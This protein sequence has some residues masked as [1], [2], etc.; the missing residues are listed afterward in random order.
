M[1]APWL[2]GRPLADGAFAALRREVIFRGCKWD[3]QVGDVCTV[4]RAPLVLVRA[5]W[6]A[7]VALAERLDVELLEMERELLQRPDLIGQLALPRRLARALPGAMPEHALR[8]HRYDFHFTTEGIRLSEVNADVPG[9]LHEGVIAS[10]YA[11][12]SQGGRV[13][14]NVAAEL[15]AAVAARVPA[16]ATVA[17]VHATAYSDDR[18]V[19]NVLER[20][21]FERGLHGIAC[22]PDHLCWAPD[23]CEIVLGARREPV[24][25]VLR[26][27]PAEWLPACPSDA[28]WAGLVRGPVLLA[29]PVTS[30]LVQSKRL[31]L[32]WPKLRAS[33]AVWRS[34]LPPTYPSR[35]FF[36][37]G[38]RCVLKP[39]LGRVGEDIV[40]RGV[41][42]L[43][44]LA[45]VAAHALLHPRDYVAQRRFHPVAW[46]VENEH[47]Y[48]CVGVFTLDGRVVG[49]Y[50][51]ASRDLFVNETAIDTPVL[52]I[53]S[54]ASR[55]S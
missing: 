13:P 44:R 30:V 10:L 34:V 54:P 33:S 21:L 3:A 28:P 8:L 25:A 29:N 12:H 20:A 22:A 35:R 1:N 15:A 49:A 26:F 38:G 23:G 32:L 4:A 43:S 46:Q 50:G 39:N 55:S 51:R 7:L 53:D 27:F 2:P 24:R 11:E 36:T 37:S 42:P 48:P 17:L 31:P 40:S 9:G 41:S 45:R 5:A 47:M 19:M 18:Q 16:G 14:G 6:D 52:V